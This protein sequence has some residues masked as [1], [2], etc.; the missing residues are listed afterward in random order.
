MIH[1]STCWCTNKKTT[2]QVQTYNGRWRQRQQQLPGELWLV[3][4]TRPLVV[5]FK[6]LSPPT[7][8]SPHSQFHLSYLVHNLGKFLVY[9]DL[10]WCNKDKQS[11]S[12]LRPNCTLKS[13]GNKDRQSLTSVE[14]TVP[15]YCMAVQP[16]TENKKEVLVKDNMFKVYLKMVTLASLLSGNQ[17]RYQYFYIWLIIKIYFR[18][19]GRFSLTWYESPQVYTLQGEGGWDVY[20]ISLLVF[21]FPARF[22]KWFHCH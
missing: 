21:K 22:A 12:P 8:A 13:K 6:C 9:T 3:W 17:E 7:P 11:F 15:L 1:S 14:E 4:I 20:I 19:D 18:L 10:P 2:H 5:R 16:P